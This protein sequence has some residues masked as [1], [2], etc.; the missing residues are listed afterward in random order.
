MMEVK[1]VK[2]VARERNWAGTEA[3]RLNSG[4]FPIEYHSKLERMQV[5]TSRGD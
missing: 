5:F 3:Q 1:K 2:K 4:S